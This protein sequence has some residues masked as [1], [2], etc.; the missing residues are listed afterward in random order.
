MSGPE[1]IWARTT[2]LGRREDWHGGCFGSVMLERLQGPLRAVLVLAAIVIPAVGLGYLVYHRYSES[3]GEYLRRLDYLELGIAADQFASRVNGWREWSR[4][5][6]G[7]VKPEGKTCADN[8]RQ[9]VEDRSITCA[10]EA[11]LPPGIGRTVD[12]KP[13]AGKPTPGAATQPDPASS[14]FVHEMDGRTSF[15]IRLPGSKDWWGY[16]P[17]STIVDQLRVDPQRFDDVLVMTSDHRV[18]QGG[19][20]AGSAFADVLA[21][22]S[23][24]AAS[25]PPAT[26]AGAATPKRFDPTQVATVSWQNENHLVFVQRTGITLPVWQTGADGK[27][28]PLELLLAGVVNEARFDEERY[29]IPYPWVL[30]AVLLVVG[31]LLSWPLLAIG[32]LR[33]HERLSAT[34]VRV[35]GLA[36]IGLGGLLP[37]V[38]LAVA[39]SRQLAADVDSQLPEIAQRLR[40]NVQERIRSAI[41]LMSPPE[42]SVSDKPAPRSRLSVVGLDGVIREE[43]ETKSD[44]PWEWREPRGVNVSDRA[45]FNTLRR[46]MMDWGPSAGSPDRAADGRTGLWK[47]GDTEYVAEVVRS[48]RQNSYR[49]AVAKALP[50]RRLILVAAMNLDAFKEPVL[51]PGVD[52]AIIDQAGTVQLHSKN[53]R[54]VVENFY[55]ALDDPA[56]MQAAV[57]DEPPSMLTATYAGTN[58][59]FWVDRI[60]DTPWSVVV[61]RTAE[62][63]QTLVVE[64][65]GRCALLFAGYVAFAFA[66]ILLFEGVTGR[67]RFA[68]LWPARSV[69]LGRYVFV[70]ARSG[71]L[72]CLLWLA[73]DTAPTIGRVVL[74]G[75][76][77]LLGLVAA[78]RDL[79]HGRAVTTA[80]ERR[81]AFTLFVIACAAVAA[82]AAIPSTDRLAWW[83]AALIIG[84]AALPAPGFLGTEATGSESRFRAAY[85][86][87]VVAILALLSSLPATVLFEDASSQVRQEFTRTLQDR[88]QGARTENVYRTSFVDGAPAPAEDVST[89]TRPPAKHLSA[90]IAHLLPVYSP[91]IA[92]VRERRGWVPAWN[93]EWRAVLLAGGALLAACLALMAIVAVVRGMFHLDADPIGDGAMLPPTTPGEATVFVYRRVGARMPD[94]E[95]PAE[96]ATIDLRAVRDPQRLGQWWTDT[97]PKTCQFELSHLEARMHDPAWQKAILDVL[98]DAVFDPTCAILLT[99]SI[100]PFE[101]VRAY[102]ELDRRVDDKAA[103]GQRALLD[104]LPRWSLVLSGLIEERY[105]PPFDEKSVR[106][107]DVREALNHHEAAAG[108]PGGDGTEGRYREIWRTLTPEERLALRQLAEEGYVS[109][110]AVHTV[111]VLM[112]RRLVQ[113]KPTLALAS[114]GFERFVLRAESQDTIA[115]WERPHLSGAELVTRFLPAALFA[116]LFL[117]FATQREVFNATTTLVGAASTAVPALLKL[118]ATG[119]NGRGDAVA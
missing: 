119:P 40:T 80:S 53:A 109:P 87:C 16:V 76:V 69:P 72:G 64:S 46:S 4:F 51:P 10:P 115:E 1:D 68:W 56:E 14:M 42:E 23:A 84:V 59:T 118:F 101:Y 85:V 30:A 117:I 3:R 31:G 2:P 100:E 22:S 79:A 108:I 93:G 21:A 70:A 24:A 65:I 90:W 75:A 96:P 13:T 116:T 114:E 11:A 82:I 103:N 45:Y 36:L 43:Y 35:L 49:L 15:Y 92:D 111:R 83:Y 27:A 77:P 57:N 91:S 105:A 99:S 113:R 39:E 48:K 71:V 66:C 60:S 17:I 98:E 88:F 67:Y 50:E 61:F 97:R 20:M 62:S 74:I 52:F 102:A 32:M 58:R 107:A 112:R 89:E 81:L 110:A 63:V 47:L 8:I 9:L 5:D 78:G 12:G 33:P 26:A 94:G 55:A 73:W 106:S 7:R 44:L 41:D 25:A 38:L 28:A 37:G 29:R 34:D 19:R 54:N 6:V 86:A 95:R 104:L 18:L